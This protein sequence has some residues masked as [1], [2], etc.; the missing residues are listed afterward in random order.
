[1]RVAVISDVHGNARALEAVL[2]ALEH[3]GTDALW[4]LGDT[5]GYGARPNECC[6]LVESVA[7][8][9]LAGNHDLVVAGVLGLEEFS[10]DAAVA[11][12]WSREQL[13]DRSRAW[14]SNLEPA[15]RVEGLEL[16]HASPRDPLW[17]YLLSAA[18]ALAAP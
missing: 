6:A 14:L 13:D 18:R 5:V 12:R 7:D 1:M 16:Y 3:A 2:A 10:H 4:C 9:S 8:L 17:E 15:A 11:A